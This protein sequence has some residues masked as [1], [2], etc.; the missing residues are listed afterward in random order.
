[1]KPAEP[2]T[3]TRSPAEAAVGK[4]PSVQSSESPPEC[5]PKKAYAYDAFISY[6]HLPLDE[7]AAEKLQM[8]LEQYRPPKGIQIGDGRKHLR[9]FRDTTELPT[10][11][12]LDTAL[13]RALLDSEY[14]I[15]I[16]SEETIHSKWCMAE[17]EEFKEAHGGSISHVLPLLVSGEPADIIPAQL[18]SATVAVQKADGSVVYEKDRVVEPLCADI[19]A[20]SQGAAMKK[21]KTEFLRLAAPLLGCGY[22]DLYRRHARRQRRLLLYAAAFLSVLAASFGALALR[23]HRT[24]QKYEENLVMTYTQQ[25]V[26]EALR[27]NR[28]GALS[29]FANA[30]GID[31]DSEVGRYGSL[32]LLQK[33][34]WPNLTNGRD[35]SLSNRSEAGTCSCTFT[36]TEIEIR[37]AGGGFLAKLPRPT[38]MNPAVDPE[39]VGYYIG[40]SPVV[41]CTDSSAFVRFGDYVYVYDIADG[42]A[43]LRAVLDLAAYFPEQ[44]EKRQLLGWGE[45][46]ISEDGSL[47]AMDSGSQ[48]AIVSMEKEIVEA[49][50]TDYFYDL[51]SVVFSHDGQA[52]A[53]VYGNYMGVGSGNPGGYIQVFDL[54]GKLL[55]DT[56]INSDTAYKGAAFSPE[57]SLLLAWEGS[58]LHFYD[59]VSGQNYAEPLECQ[60]LDAAVFEGDRIVVDSGRG[61]IYDCA[62]TQFSVNMEASSNP[63]SSQ[64]IW[65][66]HASSQNSVPVG[67]TLSIKRKV[68]SVC[69]TDA[70]GAVVSEKRFDGHLINRMCVDLKNSTAY[71]WYRDKSAL[72]RV[73]FNSAR[74]Q[75]GEVQELDTR[76]Y[77]ISD[78]CLSGDGLIAITGTGC[79]LYYAGGETIPQIMKPAMNGKVYELAVHEN[80]LAGVLISNAEN[81]NGLSDYRYDQYYG[82]ELWEYRSALRLASLET[83]NRR[84]LRN[85]RFVGQ[86]GL[87]YSKDEEELV[88]LATSAPPDRKT[89]AALNEL[90]SLVL[91]ENQSLI[92]RN[93]FADRIAF[94]NW[95]E[96]FTLS[97]KD[98]VEEDL[99]ALTEEE[100]LI[101]EADRYLR[102]KDLEGWLAFY[103][104]L[105]DAIADGSL[106]LGFEQQGVLFRDYLAGARNCAELTDRAG[107]GIEVYMENS[108]A[109]SMKEPYATMSFDLQMA[110]MLVLTGAYDELMADYWHRCAD[111]ALERFRQTGEMDILDY[112]S[113]YENRMLE[114][115]VRGWGADA[116]LEACR[117]I[118]TD[119]LDYLL[120]W[121]GLGTCY[122]LA[123]EEPEQAA[124]AFNLYIDSL[125]ELD[126]RDDIESLFSDI[127]MVMFEAS[128]LERANGLESDV[129]DRFLGHTG[130][131]FGLRVNKLSAQNR[132]YGLQTGDLVVAIDGRL[133]SSYQHMLRLQRLYPDA[134]LSYLRNGKLLVTDTIPDWDISGEFIVVEK[135]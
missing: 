88:W 45:I 77:E 96:L 83:Q 54:N 82:A 111:Y 108:V 93:H 15:V 56:G 85:I 4:N 78:A 51:N 48:T 24:E 102:A 66:N 30:L 128:F 103:D 104:G 8:L 127:M 106:P 125:L 36:E 19:R 6:R 32:L 3:S 13:Q 55:F 31:R 20:E 11:G 94:G 33:S 92:A 81:V 75:L 10:S 107:R 105:W 61:Q 97:Q 87:S 79:L 38:E 70:D 25:G 118:G 49:L 46:W 17:I 114:L 122:E 43:G 130:F 57:D 23:I 98:A 52:F 90:S 40:G 68:D 26:S 100:R 41:K 34:R 69:L 5:S 123:L 28:Q 112:C 39:S 71:L 58:T 22:D 2:E 44:A 63:S 50:L 134:A 91:S 47:L 129:M 117:E 133:I 21:L 121:T 131:N 73:P 95:G 76:G 1:M 89:V 65:D 110:Q 132:Q 9:L 113:I 67:D 135:S 14:L 99:P 86:G 53:L 35:G 101:Q 84:P 116:F 124:E 80:G 29:Y 37:G 119:Y 27:G 7:A 72:L 64:Y 74:K 16:L 60:T 59:I 120:T 109:Q 12:S 62:F 115:T 42:E 126:P 18:R